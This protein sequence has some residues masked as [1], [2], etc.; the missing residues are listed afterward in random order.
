[1][2]GTNMLL[3]RGSHARRLNALSKML[4]ATIWLRMVVFGSAA[5][6]HAGFAH[7]ALHL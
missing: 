2:V 1:M 7:A 4:L 6:G 3:Q 5:L